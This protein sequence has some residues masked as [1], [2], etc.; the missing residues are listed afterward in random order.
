MLGIEIKGI[1][2]ETKGFVRAGWG[3]YGKRKYIKIW[4]VGCFVN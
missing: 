4:L 2:F 3:R 1:C